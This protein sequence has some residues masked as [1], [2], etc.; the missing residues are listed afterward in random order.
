MISGPIPSPAATVM[1]VFSVTWKP[2]NGGALSPTP[3]IPCAR[4]EGR[5]RTA[6]AYNRK[7]ISERMS[8]SIR[9]REMTD[10]TA[11]AVD[12]RD[13]LALRFDPTRRLNPRS[14][15]GGAFDRGRGFHRQRCFLAR[16][17]DP[18]S[19]VP[20]KDRGARRAGDPSTER[21][22]HGQRGGPTSRRLSSPD[23]TG[24][25]TFRQLRRKRFRPG[26][27]QVVP[28]PVIEDVTAA[29]HILRYLSVL[30]VRD[31][32][33]RGDGKCAAVCTGGRRPADRSHPRLDGHAAVPPVRRGTGWAGG[34]AKRPPEPS[35]GRVDPGKGLG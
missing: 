30:R 17:G 15:M 20:R 32:S 18:G 25:N 26:P 6:P 4:G 35:P 23:V 16:A 1:G 9:Y 8:A 28:P 3:R 31:R 13:G 12:L 19:V 21:P 10:L 14:R 24:G 5:P 11:S 34:P 33:R 22:R 7:G 27:L 2:P 29:R